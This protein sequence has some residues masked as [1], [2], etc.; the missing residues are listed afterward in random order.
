[1]CGNHDVVLFWL[2]GVLSSHDCGDSPPFPNAPVGRGLGPAEAGV[3]GSTDRAGTGLAAALFRPICAAENR[4][5][6]D[7]SRFSGDQMFGTKR[8][9]DATPASSDID[10][11]AA[12]RPH[13]R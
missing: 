8:G 10:R 1:V 4:N 3:F 5:G 11:Q 12:M 2:V 7:R 13:V 9:S 6:R